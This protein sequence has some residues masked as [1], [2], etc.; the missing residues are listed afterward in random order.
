[1]GPG[2]TDGSGGISDE[3]ARQLA[4]EAGERRREAEA[5]RR[6]VAAQGLGTRDLDRLLADLRALERERVYDDTE[7]VAR[8][9]SNV[10]EGFRA[11]E[12]ALRRALGGAGDRPLVGRAVEAPAEYRALVEEYYRS[13]ARTPPR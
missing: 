5:L 7:E 4:R 11:F 12:F 1:G 13:L 3:Q 9:Q 10:V 8:L 2:R 6:A